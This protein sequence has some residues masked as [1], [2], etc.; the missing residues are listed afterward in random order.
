MAQLKKQPGFYMLA[1]C[2]LLSV[3]AVTSTSYN[4]V[5]YFRDCGMTATR[6]SRLYGTMML[7]LSGVKLV[8]GALCDA[9]GAKRVAI[10]CHISCATGLALLLLL[11]QTDFAMILALLV[12]D[13]CMPM[14]TLLFPLLSVELFGY[15]SQ[16]QFLGVIMSMTSASTIL[17]GP[18]SNFIY[19]RVGSYV[20]VFLC[21]IAIALSLTLV[22]LILFASI[23]K[24]KARLKQET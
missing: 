19:D 10:I 12:F 21:S 8:A 14:T 15:Q 18:V 1:A 16:S 2:A 6:A 17:S 9:I 24:S 13:F 23:K 22:Y 3:F 4:I 7:I 11:P 20:P 5:P